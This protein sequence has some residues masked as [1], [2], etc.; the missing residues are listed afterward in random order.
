MIANGN[1]ALAGQSLRSLRRG[2]RSF[3]LA[4]DDPSFCGGQPKPAQALQDFVAEVISVGSVDKHQ[5]KLPGFRSKALER[6]EDIQRKYA[7]AVGHL[8]RKQIFFN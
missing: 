2:R 5:V 1:D 6:A 8:H 4:H 3:G 7:A